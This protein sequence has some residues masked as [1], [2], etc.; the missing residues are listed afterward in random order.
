MPNTKTLNHIEAR[1]IDPAHKSLE[2]LS[3][4]HDFKSDWID[5]DPNRVLRDAAVLVPIIDR[6]QGLSVLLTKRAD[7]LNSHAGQVSFPGGRSEEGDRSLEETALRETEE[8]VGLSRDFVTLKG[9]LDRYETG[10]GF[11]IY[12]VV[13]FVREGFDLT[14]DT[15]EVAEAFEVPLEFLMNPKNHLRHS[16]VWKG[17]RREYYAMPYGEYYIWGATAGMLVNLYKRVFA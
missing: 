14:I 12:P 13:G 8:E 17:K 10:T 5:P 3:G 9:A 6:A 15:G 16:A 11:S 7:H 2:E 4:D 1:L